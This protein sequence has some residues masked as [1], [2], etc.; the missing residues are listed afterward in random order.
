M[1]R[2]VVGASDYIASDTFYT[3]CD[4]KSEDLS[5]FSIDRDKAYLI[6]I[7]QDALA[8]N[9][10]IIFFASPWSAPGWMKR[11]EDI[12][13]ISVKEKK[14]G[15][16]NRLKPEYIETF[17]RYLSKFVQSYAEEGVHIKAVTLQN[18]PQFDAA[19]YPCMR[20]T[21]DDYVALVPAFAK[22]TQEVGLNTKVLLHDHN[23]I[24]H[25]DDTKVVSGDK[26]MDPLTLVKSLQSMKALAPYIL[27]SAWHCYSGSFADMQNVYTSL[28]E[29][30]E[31]T[32]I[33][34]S[35]ATA[36]KRNRPFKWGDDLFW[37]L[38]N[39]WYATFKYGGAAAQQWNLVLDHKYGPTPRKDSAAYGLVTVETDTFQESKM[40]REFYAMAHISKAIGGGGHAIE[41]V[42]HE[43]GKPSAKL[44]TVAF[45]RT[46]GSLGLFVINNSG[47][48]NV[49]LTIKC[50]NL[51]FD[52]TV[53]KYS[54][55]T[56]IW[57]ESK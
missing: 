33:V 41:S 31:D 20:L 15:V 28:R 39:N 38:Y 55:A 52:V 44:R 40:E 25:S 8:I 9:P 6:P 36:W 24:L 30:F 16:E 23:W 1:I 11:N 47:K 14:A 22:A 7:L 4:E 27:G 57:S 10:D 51:T 46:D 21:R 13:G 45:K 53:P 2:L 42:L 32:I 48:S 50:R 54:L 43:G 37:G 34:T 12:N 5:K 26:K 3:Y 18:E 29:E 17:A 56:Y 35:E 49:D 19:H